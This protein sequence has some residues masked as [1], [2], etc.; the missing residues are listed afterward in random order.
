MTDLSQALED[1]RPIL[2]NAL[3]EAENELAQ[4]RQREAELEAL[5]AR[6]RAALGI[7]PAPSTVAQHQERL[8]LHAAI[9]R[10]LQENNNRWMHVRELA[11]AINE[12]QLYEKRDKSPVEPNQIHAR[13]RNYE[14]LFDKDGP[15]IRLRPAHAQTP[16]AETD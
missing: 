9:E 1:T 14:H 15:R 8:T 10:V 11:D 7:E 16:V 5:I 6:A 13:T 12:E 3:T 2:E 4:L